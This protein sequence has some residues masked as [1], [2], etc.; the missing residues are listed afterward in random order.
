MLVC[1]FYSSFYLHL[2]ILLID[3]IGDRDTIDWHL[4]FELNMKMLNPTIFGMGSEFRQKVTNQAQSVCVFF[5]VSPSLLLLALYAGAPRFDS[6][7][8]T[9]CVVA[10]F[11]SIADN[12]ECADLR[13]SFIIIIMVYGIL[14]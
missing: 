3:S 7:C 1:C 14:C 9:T 2:T 13:N 5:F 6:F 10:F 11:G 8:S 12:A 4:T